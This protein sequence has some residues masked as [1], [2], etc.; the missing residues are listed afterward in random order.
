MKIAIIGSGVSG[1]LAAR[2][3]AAEHDIDVFEA[4]D[5]VGGHTNTVALEAFG[6]EYA[7]DT[8]FMVFND[9][10]YPLPLDLAASHGYG[11]RLS[12]TAA[13][14]PSNATA[15]KIVTRSIGSNAGEVHNLCIRYST[16]RAASG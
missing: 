15:S 3:I 14:S 5:Y 1:L 4:N 13:R 6:R 16:V 11:S 10:T 8:G 7:V 2:L 12:I 9:R